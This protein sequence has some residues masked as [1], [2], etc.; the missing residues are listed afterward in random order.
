MK[1]R[2]QEEGFALIVLIVMIFVILLFLGIAAPLVARDLQREKELESVHRA[3]Q[4][5][6]AIQLYYRRFNHY[7]TSVDQ[8]EKTNNIRFLRRKYEDPLTGKADWRIIH[9]GENKTTVKGLFG[10]P[11]AGIGTALGGSGIGGTQTISGTSNPGAFG[12][13]G[14]TGTGSTGI[15][16]GTQT[17][18]GTSG[19]GNSG[20]GSQSA[21]TFQGGGGPIMGI[22]SSKSGESILTENEQT[23]YQDWEF[24]YDPRIEQLKAKSSLFG[25]GVGGGG[26]GG[27]GGSTPGTGI[28]SP[29]TPFGSPT[30]STGSTGA[31]GATT[32]Q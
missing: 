26:G 32:P 9:A 2:P 21:T 28:G 24:L 18:G 25:G 8:L 22:G 17:V 13:T 30:G 1:T 5:V 19:S 12:S 20:F 7:P 29:I 3:N 31:T 23:N 11:L 6:R 14:S 15:G 4:Y 10:Q 16:G 27:I